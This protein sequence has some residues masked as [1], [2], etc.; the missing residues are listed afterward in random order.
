MTFWQFRRI[1]RYATW[2]ARRRPEPVSPLAWALL[3]LALLFLLT[4]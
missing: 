1:I 3:A 4:R 2:E